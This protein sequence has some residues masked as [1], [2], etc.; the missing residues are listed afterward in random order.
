MTERPGTWLTPS[1]CGR[2][3]GYSVSTFIETSEERIVVDQIPDPVVHFFEADV[4]TVEGLAEEVLSRVQ[5]EGAGV[6]D[7]TD[8]KVCGVLG[9]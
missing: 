4:F 1:A 9:W 7:A 5:A 6:A 3:L 8:F 2:G